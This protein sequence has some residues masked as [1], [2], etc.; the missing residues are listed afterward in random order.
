MT[1]R[2]QPDKPPAR[3]G[4]ARRSPKSAYFAR[5]WEICGRGGQALIEFMIGLV[6]VLALVAGLFQIASLVKSH[7]DTMVEA[8]RQAGELANMELDQGVMLLSDADYIRDWEEGNDGKR[9]TRD[10]SF[11]TADDQAFA[12]TF[13]GKAVPSPAGWDVL[14]QAPGDRL[15]AMNGAPNPT[16]YF[17]LVRGSSSINAPLFQAARGLFHQADSIEVRCDVWMTWTKGIY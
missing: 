14:C 8:R 11:T 10:D 4:R 2:S 1:N 16:P 15:S 7:T 3:S 9:H 13:V 6:A 17:G 5:E 12:A